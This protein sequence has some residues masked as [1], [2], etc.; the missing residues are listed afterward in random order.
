ME[1]KKKI[2]VEPR[3][4]KSTRMEAPPEA[5]RKV[6]ELRNQ[7]LSLDS[8][9]NKIKELYNITPTVPTIQKWYDEEIAFGL[10]ASKKGPKTFDK[11]T[12]MME[13]RFGSIVETMDRL[14]K[15]ANLLLDEFE[16][17]SKDDID[18]YI[19]FMKTSPMIIAIVKEI[20]DQIAFIREEQ[21]RIK[22]EQ[23]NFIYS[24]LQIS[25]QFNKM[26]ALH[27][28]AGNI[29]I[30][31]PHSVQVTKNNQDLKGGKEKNEE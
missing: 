13:E 11:Y 20:K 1:D 23:K 29:K 21:D 26:L 27:V 14:H 12:D 10:L 31:K 28:K 17:R 5:R 8:I 7:G 6:V 4:L 16:A 22:I 25:Q 18:A 24:P 19:K 9:A 2:Y 15:A 3:P 30:L